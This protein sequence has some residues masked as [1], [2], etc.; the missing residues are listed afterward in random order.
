MISILKQSLLRAKNRMKQLADR[1]RSERVFDI[2]DWVFVKIHPYCQSTMRYNK[3]SKL[4]P[5]YYGSFLVLERMGP[6]AYKS[7]LPNDVQVH[8]TFH[9]SLLK[10]ANGPPQQVIPSPVEPRFKFQPAAI[11]ERVYKKGHQ[12]S[13]QVLVH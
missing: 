13:M 5:K 12:A 1:H 2:G 11:L 4:S 10:R 9:V 7:D 3:F 6:V 8:H